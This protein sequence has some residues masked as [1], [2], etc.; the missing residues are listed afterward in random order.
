MIEQYLRHSYYAVRTFLTDSL[1]HV[2]EI[3]NLLGR[4]GV[5]LLGGEFFSRVKTRS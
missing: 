5:Y 1:Q 3:D 2:S 4:T